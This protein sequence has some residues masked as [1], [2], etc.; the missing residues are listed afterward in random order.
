MTEIRIEKKKS[1]WP[2]V[3]LALG[4]IALLVYLFWFRDKQSAEPTQ[5]DLIN[6][7]ENNSAVVAFVGFVEADTAKMTLDHD[8]SHQSLLKLIDATNG[9][10]GEIG[11]EV[12]GDL[13]KAKE[14]ADSITI[15]PL[16][17]THAD[18]IKRAGTI[19]AGVLKNMQKAKYPGLSS[20]ANEV[21]TAAENINPETLTLDQRG[22]VRTFFQKAANLLQK[23]N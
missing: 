20:E 8:F 15:D 23:M 17:T 9:M 5:T 22:V 4:I 10:A 11:F 21:S 6:V 3:F 14:C 13:A 19:V 18:N 1:L 12:K 2:W 7:H 16:A